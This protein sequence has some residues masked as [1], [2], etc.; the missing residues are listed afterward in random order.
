MINEQTAFDLARRYSVRRASS[1]FAL[2]AVLLGILGLLFGALG[3]EDILH[4]DGSG[5]FVGAGLWISTAFFAA[6]ALHVLAAWGLRTDKGWS[7]RIA[8][9]LHALLCAAGVIVL[10]VSMLIGFWI[11]SV[12]DLVCLAVLAKLYFW[13]DDSSTYIHGELDWDESLNVQDRGFEPVLRSPAN[14]PSA[15]DRSK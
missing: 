1:L 9:I 8:F 14:R 11:V 7:I 4:D 5:D 10:I 13:I 6:A 2:I 15:G 12:I 3:I